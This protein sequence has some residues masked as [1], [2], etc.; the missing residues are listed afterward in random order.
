MASASGI[1]ETVIDFLVTDGVHWYTMTID[2][3]NKLLNRTKI[4]CEEAS[5]SSTLTN[6]QLRQKYRVE[7]VT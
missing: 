5:A 6:R 3:V 2:I 4:I 7:L 1:P